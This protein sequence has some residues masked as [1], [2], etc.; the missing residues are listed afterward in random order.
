MQLV[1]VA[2]L[3]EGHEAGDALGPDWL[4]DPIETFLGVQVGAYCSEDDPSGSWVSAF[5]CIH[6]TGDGMAAIAE[7][8]AAAFSTPRG[9]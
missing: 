6:P 7:A 1:D 5:D 3:F 2:S 8:V 4:R 9:F